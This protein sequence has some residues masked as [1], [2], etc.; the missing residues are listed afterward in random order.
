MHARTG[1]ISSWLVAGA[2]VVGCGDDGDDGETTAGATAPTSITGAS[3]ATGVTAGTGGETTGGDS[4]ATTSVDPSGSPTSAPT[5]TGGPGCSGDQDCPEGQHC[6]SW[7]GQCLPAGGCVFDEDC[8]GGQTCN[9]GVCEIG[10]ECGAQEFAL[11]QVVPNVMIVLDRSGSMDGDVQDSDKNRWEVAKDAIFKLV[12]TFNEE[13][14]FGL[15]TYSACV[16]NGCSAGTIVV[17]LAEFNGGA[18]QQFLADKGNGY[19]CDSGD[20]ETSTGNTLKALVGEPQ[21]QDPTRGNAVLLITDGNESGEC[22]DPNDGPSAAAELF[23]QAI[24]VPT[25]AVGFSDGILGSLAEIATSGG[26]GM[27]YNANN[28]ASLEAALEAIAGAVVSCTFELDTVPDDPS[29]IYVFF[30]DMIPGLPNDA[31]NGWTYDPSTNTITFHGTACDAL[32]DGLVD[33]VDVVFGCDVPIP[34]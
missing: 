34:G 27:P 12:T 23:A 3:G 4:D 8:D 5:T 9:D 28:P 32:K 14:R 33:D 20:P 26:T 21:I 13:I 31:G 25:Y 24:S 19:L 10:G 7:S 16:G 11:T 22:Q 18:I 29:E 1:R 15:V 6:G 2:L 17:P 30:E